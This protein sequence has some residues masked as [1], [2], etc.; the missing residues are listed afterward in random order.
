MSRLERALS[1][2]PWLSVDRT[3]WPERQAVAPEAGG[4]GRGEGTKAAL[5]AQSRE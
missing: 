5:L 3:A 1:L 4:K 2:K